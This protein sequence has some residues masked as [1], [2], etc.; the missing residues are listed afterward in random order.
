[1][2]IKK[3]L[4]LSFC[5]VFT[6][7]A[8]YYFYP[9]QKIPEGVSIDKIIVAKSKHK[10]FAYSKGQLV[11]TYKVAIGKDPTGRKEFEGD[12]KTPEGTYTIFDKNSHSEF[13]K[14]LGISYPNQQDITQAQRIGKAPGREIKIHGLKNGQGYI[15]KF[16]RWRDWT[17]GCLALTNDE[18]DQLYDH[19][20]IGTLIE[21]IK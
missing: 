20:P 12:M 18:M 13:H 21:I 11:V 9:V 15:G 3:T 8:I 19:T 7:F 1:M 14:N 10:L 16:H 4:A 17:D 5:A 6:G 2:S